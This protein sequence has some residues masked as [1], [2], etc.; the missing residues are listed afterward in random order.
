MISI[1][2]LISLLVLLF[3]IYYFLFYR[4]VPIGI[5]ISYWHFLTLQGWKSR[6][7]H[8]S[9]SWSLLKLVA[10]LTTSVS[11]R[12]WFWLFG[13]HQP[14]L[15]GWLEGISLWKNWMSIITCYMRQHEG[16][17]QKGTIIYAAIE[18]G[19]FS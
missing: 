18:G 12:N 5:I 15:C 7:Y 8:S 6:K 1:L 4:I 16:F 11:E 3:K 17:A 10:S 9:V 2:I 14:L 19:K 13:W